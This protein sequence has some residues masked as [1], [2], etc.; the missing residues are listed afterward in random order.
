[1]R[2]EAMRCALVLA[3]AGAALCLAACSGRCPAQDA[4]AE[5][6][7]DGPDILDAVPEVDADDVHDASEDGGDV[8]STCDDADPCTEDR[9][10]PDTGEC[11][12]LGLD[13]DEDGYRAMFAPDGTYCDA[14]DC[15]DARDDVHPGAV[16][17]CGDGLDQDCDGSDGDLG[18]LGPGIM[19]S[20]DDIRVSRNPAIDWSGS[21]FGV[22]WYDD[23]P[24]GRGT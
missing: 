24:E 16:E 10:D 21:E 11:V 9:I 5:P 4:L 23:R 19:L 1:M 15:D 13:A 7:D 20:A 17:V 14:T 6:E 18:L 2:S 22:A 12:H 8:T 3:A